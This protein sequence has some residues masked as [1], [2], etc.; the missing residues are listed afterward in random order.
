M[1][2]DMRNRRPFLSSASNKLHNFKGYLA[3]KDPRP[4]SPA[5]STPFQRGSGDPS[6]LGVDLE[7]AAR[8]SWTQW[9]GEKLRRNGQAQ[10][11]NTSIVEKVS[12]FPGWATRRLHQSSPGEGA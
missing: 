5:P 4:F 11:N 12:L 7:P 3:S 1:S 8:Q 6:T 9:A 2:E 10:G